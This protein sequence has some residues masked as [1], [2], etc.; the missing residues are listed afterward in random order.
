MRGRRRKAGTEGRRE[1]ICRTARLSSLV[2]HSFILPPSPF[3]LLLDP[4]AAGAWNMAVDEALLEAA[5]AEG[6]C[7]LRFYRWQ[8]PTLSLGYFQAYADRWQHAASSQC[9][10]GP[11]PERRR[12]HPAR[13]RS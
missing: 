6:Q 7:T 11:S 4:P 5:A 1:R 2:I 8:E 13:P 3:R 12:G 10:G 9:R